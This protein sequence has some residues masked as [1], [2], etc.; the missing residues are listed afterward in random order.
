M[1]QECP[2]SSLIF[3]IVLEFLAWSIRQIGKEDANY[4]IIHRWYDSKFT[5][6]TFNVFMHVYFPLDMKYIYRR[7]NCL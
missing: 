1:T 4:Q 5:S 2:L 6:L 7:L 3:N